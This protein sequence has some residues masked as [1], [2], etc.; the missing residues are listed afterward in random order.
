[1]NDDLKK[2]LD[3]QHDLIFER[4]GSIDKRIEPIALIYD[5]LSGFGNVL[6]W[7][8]TILIVPLSVIIGIWYE[9][10]RGIK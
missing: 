9:V 5:N 6:K 2:Y 4:L 8:F 3:D 7:V 10:K 1:M